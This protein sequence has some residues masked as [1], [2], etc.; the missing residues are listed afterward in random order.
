VIMNKDAPPTVDEIHRRVGRNLLRFQKIE[1][2][3][4]FMIPYLRVGS[5]S[6]TV[7]SIRSAQARVRKMRLGRLIDEF[8]RAAEQLDSYWVS[9]L[10][11]VLDARNELVH[12]FYRNPHFSLLSQEGASRALAYLNEQ[13]QATDEWHKALRTQG[14][15]LLINVIDANPNLASEYARHRERLI[16]SLPPSMEFVDAIEPEGTQCASTRIINLLRLAELKTEPVNGMTLLARAGQMIASVAPGTNLEED[17]GLG[18]LKK[19][20]LMSGLF[21][22]R[23]ADDGTTVSYRSNGQLTA[24]PVDH[25]PAHMSVSIIRTS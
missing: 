19:I 15:V 10:Q 7:E 2:F 9:E 1:E 16:A 22:V 8:K 5:E 18:S 20:L 13:H 17:Y 23:I 12:E 3:L 24:P 21:E 25:D 11:K 6:V 14:T 4:R